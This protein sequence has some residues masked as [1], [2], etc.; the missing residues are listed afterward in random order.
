MCK[1]GDI[2]VIDKYKTED[3]FDMS[4]HSFIVVDDRACIPG[5][6]IKEVQAI[7]LCHFS[8]DIIASVMSSIKDSEHRKKVLK[9]VEN[10][11][12]TP[13]DRLC[14]PENGKDAYVKVN[15]LHYFNRLKISYRV[16]GNVTDEVMERI[17]DLMEYLDDIGRLVINTND[18]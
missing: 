6:H 1:Y 12:I 5:L 17:M 11:E 14:L 7:L 4:R 16:I 8:Y 15:Q 3:G 13:L 18:L 10:M 9:R 2:I